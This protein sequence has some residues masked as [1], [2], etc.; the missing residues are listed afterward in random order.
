[1]AS[2][3]SFEISNE[4]LLQQKKNN[5]PHVFIKYITLGQKVFFFFK[6]DLLV[7]CLE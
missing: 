3:I 4:F 5:K 2:L 1:M 6:Y 7:K